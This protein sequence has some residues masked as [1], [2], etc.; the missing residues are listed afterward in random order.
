[1][2]LFRSVFGRSVAVSGCHV[3]MRRNIRRHLQEQKYLQTL[4]VKNI[5]FNF[6][7]AAISALAYVPLEELLSY[8][9]ALIDEELPSVMDNIR[10]QLEVEE[11]DPSERFADIQRSVERFLDYI[12]ATYIG[13]V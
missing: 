5:R 10:R 11:D 9:K 1:M 13:K 12:E 3:H 6:F 7:V 8:Y 2:I 4:A